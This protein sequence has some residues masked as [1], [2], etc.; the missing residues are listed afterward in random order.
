MTV[1][2]DTFDDFCQWLID[3]GL[4]PKRSERLWRKTIYVRLS[5]DDPMTL[6][7]F[8]DFL[9]DQAKNIQEDMPDIDTCLLIGLTIRCE[10]TYKKTITNAI[11]ADGHIH[12][13]FDDHSNQLVSKSNCLKL[14][15]P[16]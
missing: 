12:L 13:F 9:E 10:N 15:E 6:D 14:L 7:N 2:K 5:Y 1:D 4:R 16:P 3:D 8:H 11:E